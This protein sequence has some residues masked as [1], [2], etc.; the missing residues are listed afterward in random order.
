E[1]LGEIVLQGAA[2]PELVRDRAPRW[3]QGDDVQVVRRPLPRALRLAR[4]AVGGDGEDAARGER[5]RRG[6]DLA[7]VRV[8]ARLDG[9]EVGDVHAAAVAAHREA[10]RRRPVQAEP[11]DR[12]EIAAEDD[13]LPGTLTAHV[14]AV[15]GRARGGADGRGAGA[16]RAVSYV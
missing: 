16:R 15:T 14:G 2:H 6:V 9:G 12:R 8:V 3:R 11:R 13:E 10:A 1:S 5:E 4:A 7:H